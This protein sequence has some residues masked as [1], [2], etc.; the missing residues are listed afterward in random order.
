MEEQAIKPHSITYYSDS[1]VVLGNIGNE[2]R[3]FYVYVS[4]RVERIRKSSSPEEWCCV[5]TQLNPADCATRSAKANELDN[6]MWLS[7]PKFL[8][9]QDPHYDASEECVV[10]ES[11]TDDPEVRPDAKLKRLP[12]SNKATR[13]SSDGTTEI[14]PRDGAVERRKQAETVIIKNVLQ[15]VFAKEIEQT[16][17]EEKLPK[18]S[19][20]TNLTPMI[21]SNGLVRV[22]GR[23]ERAE[24]TVE[25]R[26]PIILPGSHHITTLMAEIKAIVNNRPLIPVS[27]DPEAPEIPTSLTLLTQKST[28]L[29]ATPGQFTSKDLHTA[30]WRQVQYL[31]N[32][33][34]SRWR[35]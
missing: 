24:L 9:D 21:N 6:S 32:V 11:F 18:G 5:P 26:H 2:T 17:K 16:K 34:W 22:G 8:R 29:T 13:E 23:L 30:Q 10:P 27:N 15:E 3:R 35:K 28:A 7:G 25:E 19:V 33:F 31:A 14:Q 4:N 1:K 12:R 20:L